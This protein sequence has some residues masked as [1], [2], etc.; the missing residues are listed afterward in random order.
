M[1]YLML[2]AVLGVAVSGPAAAATPQANAPAK[3]KR[4]C[5][6]EIETGS[7]VKKRKTCKTRAEWDAQVRT[8]GDKLENMRQP[9]NSCGATTFGAC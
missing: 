7:L 8:A 9:I 2:V 1:R 5:R 6:S 3:E 4:I